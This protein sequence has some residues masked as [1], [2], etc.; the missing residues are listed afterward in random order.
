[1]LPTLL[2]SCGSAEMIP[3]LIVTIKNECY[4]AIVREEAQTSQYNNLRSLGT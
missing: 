3:E 1:M 2:I 4:K